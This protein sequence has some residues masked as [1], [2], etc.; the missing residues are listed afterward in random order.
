MTR[1]SLFLFEFFVLFCLIYVQFFEKTYGN[2]TIRKKSS[3]DNFERGGGP[4]PLMTFSE[5]NLQIIYPS[6]NRESAWV[7]QGCQEHCYA[8]YWDQCPEC[9]AP[10]PADE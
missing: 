7:Y 8:D 3:F 4:A 6:L 1:F 9:N 10:R 2:R 5:K